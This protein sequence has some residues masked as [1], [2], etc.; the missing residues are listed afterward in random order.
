VSSR[1][2]SGK[3]SSI[4]SALIRTPTLGGARQTLIDYRSRR[5]DPDPGSVVFRMLANVHIG[6]HCFA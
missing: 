1:D 3:V 4:G 2:V 6:Q 5:N